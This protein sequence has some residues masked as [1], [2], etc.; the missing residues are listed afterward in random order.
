M[1]SRVWDGV[2]LVGALGPYDDSE[3]DD[4]QADPEVEVMNDKR[5]ATEVVIDF[6]RYV[7]CCD[8]LPG[9]YCGLDG[10][11]LR[12]IREYLPRPMVYLAF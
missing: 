9:L 8:R 7:V 5:S 3:A 11:V 6:D 2:E 10:H 1:V 4:E 12:E